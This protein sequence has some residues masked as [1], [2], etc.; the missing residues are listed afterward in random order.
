MVNILNCMKSKLLVLG[1]LL[2][3]CSCR[4]YDDTITDWY[5]VSDDLKEWL[6]VDSINFRFMV[7]DNHS[8]GREF[9]MIENGHEFS[10]GSSYFA[11]IKYH[12]SQREN[13]YQ[14]FG[15]NY[16]DSYSISLNPTF[17]DDIFGEQIDFYLQNLSFSYDFKF[18][19]I[20]RLETNNQYRWLTITSEGIEDNTLFQ[21]TVEFLDEITMN[22]QIYFDILHFQL[23]DFE[24]FW[25]E[26]TI[27]EVYYARKLGLLR[28]KMNNGLTFERR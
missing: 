16:G 17:N 15:S 8:I 2:Y 4:I 5:Y 14:R 13:Y 21:S 11:G 18:E 1:L 10:P 28:Y 24:P 22:D 12:V 27:T 9:V 6:V 25:N 26:N 20:I 19:E 7:K 3:L 23:K